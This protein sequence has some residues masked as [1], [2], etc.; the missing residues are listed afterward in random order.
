MSVY[1][2]VD[3]QKLCACEG[4]CDKEDTCTLL[5][6]VENIIIGLIQYL[7]NIYSADFELY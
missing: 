5:N 2:V 4:S 1:N 6:T 3:M 7:K